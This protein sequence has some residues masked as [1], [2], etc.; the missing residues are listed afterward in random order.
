MTAVAAHRYSVVPAD[1]GGDRAR[2]LEFWQR[3]GFST[4]DRAER[5]DWFHL[6]NPEGRGRIYLLMLEGG[7]QIV[8]TACAGTRLIH[9]PGGAVLRASVLVDFAVDPAH[10][11]LGP[12]LTL[13]RAAREYEKQHADLLY[14]LPDTRAVPIFKRLGADAALQEASLAYVVRSGGYLR[15][16]LPQWAWL[17]GSIAGGVIDL[18]RGALL[19]IRAMASDIECNW[20][21]EPP[22]GVDAL[23]SQTAA[24][25]DAGI[26][27]RDRRYLEWRFRGPEWRFAAV[28]SK[29]GSRLHAYMA[30]RQIGDELHIGDLLLSGS[31]PERQRALRAFLVTSRKE[32]VRVIRVDLLAPAPAM[33]AM[34]A[35]GFSVRGERPLFLIRNPAGSAGSLVSSW[36]FTRADED[37]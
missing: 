12:A 22:A 19:R 36:W 35:T 27:V 3:I 8:G 13:Q 32:P 26:G 9:M 5:Y 34:Q 20:C 1:I 18:A 23:W 25:L 15:R 31:G 7:D 10:R 29:G 17:A 28:T 6:R 4:P 33:N 16:K 21:A 2:I 37:V 11:S 24:D 30:C 14:G